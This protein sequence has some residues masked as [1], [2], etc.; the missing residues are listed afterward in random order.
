[1]R[2]DEGLI[3]R[4]LFFLLAVALLP[5][6]SGLLGEFSELRL[7]WVL[8]SAHFMTISA[9]LSGVWDYAARRGLTAAEV[10]SPTQH[11]LAVRGHLVRGVF[12]LSI[13]LALVSVPL[14]EL[15]PL[16][17]FPT[18]PLITRLEA[19]RQRLSTS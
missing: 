17:F 11:H 9:L 1:M 8:F 4:N 2:F 18:L 6:T 19:H 16:L 13:L 12:A 15:T 10:D 5:F 7:A 14:A 3:W